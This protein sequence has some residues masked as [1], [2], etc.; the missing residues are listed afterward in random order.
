MSKK[1]RK[2][3]ALRV[4]GLENRELM[5]GDLGI[6]MVNKTLTITGTEAGDNIRVMQIGNNLNVYNGYGRPRVTYP[7]SEVSVLNV[8][9]NGGNDRIEVKASSKVFD[10]IFIDL[11]R[12]SKELVDV[13]VGGARSATINANASLGTT[14][15]LDGYF[16]GLASVDYGTDPADDDFYTQNSSFNRLDLKTG[17]G[18]D[19]C[20][21][22]RTSVRSASI[23]MGSGDDTF[24]NA[25]NSDVQEGTIDGGNAVRGNRWS[26]PRFG[27]RVAIRGF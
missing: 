3:R 23:N 4:E 27:S 26:G 19:F 22:L 10:A 2:T 6:S 7:L 16:S 14:V 5:A 1:N 12:G 20:Q 13:G 21:L 24:R 15:Y 18:N 8:Q 9:A 25:Y 11:G 17:G